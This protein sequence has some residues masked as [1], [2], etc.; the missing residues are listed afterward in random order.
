MKVLDRYLVRELII[1]ICVA[2]LTLIF[3]VLIADIFDNLDDLLRRQIPF[4]I[5]LRYYL[6]MIPFAFTETIPWATW[7]GTI[8]LLVHF[9]F[10]NETLAMKA[11]GLKITTIVK[12]ILFLGFLIGIF[13]FIVSDRVVPRTFRT[14]SE[15]RE[16]Y[17]E[18]KKE[19]AVEKV[20]HNVTYFSRGEQLYYFRTLSKAKGEAEGVI[21]LWLHPNEANTRQKMI[22]KRAVWNEKVWVFENITEYQMDSRGRILGEPQTF[23]TKIYPEINFPPEEIVAAA[24]EST[25]LTYRELKRSIEKLKENG[26]RIH[27]ELV[28]LHDRLAS[29]WQGLV[30]MIIS[31]PLLAQTA[32]RKQIAL[33]LLVCL[34]LAFGYH[35]VEAVGLAMGKAGK[36]FPF[37]SAWSGNLI[38]ATAALVK[39]DRANY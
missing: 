28:D 25:F 5:I 1:P 24:S 20:L 27:S 14:A 10:H 26:V 8:F 37:L 4:A 22:A 23:P 18:R 19:H 36:I 15:L 16:I 33:R 7:L 11:A 6:S 12:P 32:N 21:V 31:I 3:L 38:F 30:M 9:G 13:T 17:I 29:P 39:L 34:G 35:V 2:S